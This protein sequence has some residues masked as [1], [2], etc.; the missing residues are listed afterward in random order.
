MQKLIS[1]AGGIVGL[2]G[3]LLGAFLWLNAEFAH[4]E[5]VQKSMARIA[6]DAQES[7]IE[8][9]VETAS[10]RIRSLRRWKVNNE[11]LFDEYDEAELLDLRESRKFQMERLGDIRVQQRAIK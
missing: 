9:K 6:L 11:I 10:E 7:L 5:E 4:A 8:Y 3:A 2:I 1:I